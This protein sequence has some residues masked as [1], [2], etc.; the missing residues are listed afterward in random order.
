[1]DVGFGMAVGTRPN[2]YPP[3]GT[4]PFLANFKDGQLSLTF[5]P[6]SGL[7]LDETYIYSHLGTRSDPPGTIFDNHIVRSK[8]NYQFT[9]E[10]SLRVIVDYNGVL[11]DPSLVSLERTKHLAGDVLLTYLIHPGTAFYVGYTDGYDNI[12]L[13]S[14]GIVSIN[15]PTTST[16]RQFFVKTS[17]LFRF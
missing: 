12:E 15:S 5:R 14:S 8:M 16:G 13:G 3:S 6:A 10:F 4:L 1:M 11:S 7:R 9:R 2:Y 17:Y